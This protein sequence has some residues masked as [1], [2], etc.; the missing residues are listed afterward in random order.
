MAGQPYSEKM[1]VI[2]V[3]S[4]KGGVGKTTLAANL[5]SVIA[6][7]G[8]RVLALDLDPQNALRLHFRNWVMKDVAPPPNWRFAGA[9]ALTSWEGR[10]SRVC[11][12]IDSTEAKPYRSAVGR[13]LSWARLSFDAPVAVA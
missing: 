6:A 12:R 8:R 7:R 2:T 13:A 11:T 5:A 3:V 10:G 9:S 4:A 1:K